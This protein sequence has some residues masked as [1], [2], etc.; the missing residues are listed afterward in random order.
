M[1]G[2][3]EELQTLTKVKPRR[4]TEEAGG[5]SRSG[6]LQRMMDVV[7]GIPESDWNKLSEQAQQWYNMGAEA[8]KAHKPIPEFDVVYVETKSADEDDEEEQEEEEVET[9]PSTNSKKVSKPP[10]KAKVKTK[11]KGPVKPKVKAAP[12]K[13]KIAVPLK[14]DAVKVRIKHAIIRDPQISLEDLCVVLSKGGTKISKVTTAGVRSEFRHSL[15]VL[16][17]EGK[18][19]DIKI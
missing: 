15:R 11:A 5:E 13:E 14:A 19:K 8:I 2:I 7:E 16:Q 6:Y 17:Q 4:D 3:E 18:L 1:A 9:S 12:P 10:V